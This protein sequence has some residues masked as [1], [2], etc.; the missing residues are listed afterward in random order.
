MPVAR[1][2][3]T[4]AAE[5]HGLTR[6]AAIDGQIVAAWVP[7]R[8]ELAVMPPSHKSVAL[9][10]G[11]AIVILTNCAGATEWLWMRYMKVIRGHGCGR[12]MF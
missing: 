10:F 7:A 6:V 9:L 3:C 12:R 8:P 11:T 1:A 2:V 5:R 4:G